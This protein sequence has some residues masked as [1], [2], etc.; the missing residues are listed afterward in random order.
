MN[1]KIIPLRNNVNAAIPRPNSSLPEYD[2]LKGWATCGGAGDLYYHAMSEWLTSRQTV[3]NVYDIYMSGVRYE[4]EL[5][6]FLDLS[7]GSTM[8]AES[9]R[10]RE[11]ATLF[12][13]LLIKEVDYLACKVNTVAQSRDE[14]ERT[15]PS[16]V[17]WPTRSIRPI[18]SDA[19]IGFRERV[20]A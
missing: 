6:R 19:T 8:T 13:S 18:V 9:R 17:A 7:R 12:R 10:T 14:K 15:L 4:A 20:A 5:D 2:T 3:G 1:P 16:P 11:N